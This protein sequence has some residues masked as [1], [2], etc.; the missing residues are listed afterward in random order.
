MQGS[1]I[2]LQRAGATLSL[3]LFCLGLAACGSDS[4][5]AAAESATDSSVDATPSDASGSG[6]DG[7][8]DTDASDLDTENDGSGSGD[9]AAD[10]TVEDTTDTALEDT[11]DTTVEDT[12]D[13]TVEDTTDTT[14]DDTTDTA[15]HDTTDTA[16]EDTTDT[17]VEDTTVDTTPPPF[18]ACPRYSAGVSAGFVTNL[19]IREA[20]GVAASRRYGNVLWVHNDS[21]DT[22]RVFAIAT[23]G[24]PF[25]TYLL[26]GAEADDWEDIAVGPGP[27]ADTSYVY[28]G[29]IGDNGANRNSIEVYRFPEP[30]VT[31]SLLN[32]TLSNVDRLE[33]RYPDGRGEN[34]ETLLVDPTNG[35]IYV[36]SKDGSGEARV[37][38]ASPPFV[39]LDRVTMTLVTT[40]QFGTAPLIGDTST[41]AGDFSP[42]GD[43]FAIRT[44]DT[45][46]AWRRPT[47][48]TVDAAL[49]TV[50]CPLP[51]RSEG[52]GEAFGFNRDG[53]GYFTL[54]EGSLV[55]LSSYAAR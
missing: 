48:T 4:S 31:T 43:L 45:A 6:D 18:P 15:I 53:T 22:N 26:G 49:A 38:R 54:G 19:S 55:Q 17:T 11:S 9:V 28:V 16:V 10:T 35:D 44:Y 32:I 2:G 50:P 23:N 34:A 14:V 40:L 24:A 51:V 8:T 25:A 1:R 13:T 47:G 52:Q 3:A 27:V 12:S 37:Y 21:G 39:P 29:D 33:F 42:S 5:A 30:E 46:Y 36:V 7:A 20:S 41:T